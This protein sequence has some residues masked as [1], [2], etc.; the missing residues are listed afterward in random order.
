MCVI[1]GNVVDV[2]KTKG[3][4]CYKKVNRGNS[5]DAFFMPS[6]QLLHTFSASLLFRLDIFVF[7]VDTFLTTG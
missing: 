3:E 5:R 7:C 6:Q 2:T 4:L 1:H